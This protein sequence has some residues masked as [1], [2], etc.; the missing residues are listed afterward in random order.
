MDPGNFFGSG[1]REHVQNVARRYAT[2]AM[3]WSET[4][5][6]SRGYFP[7]DIRPLFYLTLPHGIFLLLDTYFI[8]FRPLLAMP[9]AII[10]SCN[11]VRH[12]QLWHVLRLVD[13]LLLTMMVLSL[14]K[15][16]A[17]F[18]SPW[19]LL[20]GGERR[21]DQKCSHAVAVHWD[22]LEQHGTR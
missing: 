17:G 5:G 7:N 21:Y 4:R 15:A 2:C 18:L 3:F 1:F 13:A 19:Q 6:P 10:T 20:V 22:R 12:G 16:G 9:T 11:S 8:P 14:W